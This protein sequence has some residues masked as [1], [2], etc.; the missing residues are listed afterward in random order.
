MGKK[1]IQTR[2]AIIKWPK[3]LHLKE[4]HKLKDPMFEPG[5][6]NLLIVHQNKRKPG[7]RVSQPAVH[8]KYL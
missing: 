3:A 5:Q 6:G 8:S 7:L 1:L 4:K 2:G